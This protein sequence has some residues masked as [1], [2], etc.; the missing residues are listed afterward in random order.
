MRLI[1]GARPPRAQPDAPSRRAGRRTVSAPFDAL[2]RSRSGAMAHRSTVG[3]AVLPCTCCGL[4]PVASP[5]T[6]P[7]TRR[8]P[9]HGRHVARSS[10]TLQVITPGGADFPVR[11]QAGTIQLEVKGSTAAPAVVRWALA[12][13]PEWTE[14]PDGAVAVRRPARREGAVSS[15]RG[16]R[17][18]HSYCIV[19]AKRL[20]RGGAC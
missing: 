7:G 14:S 10:A 8:L 9:G 1:R 13:D 11:R 20:A 19:P 3:A 12:P 17:G 2:V 18:P 5:L 15:A 4:V 6:P 16:G